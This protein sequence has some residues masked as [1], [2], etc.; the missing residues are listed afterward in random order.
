M[1][2]ISDWALYCVNTKTCRIPELTQLESGKSMIRNLP[3]KGVA[4][5]ARTSVSSSNLEPLPPAMIIAI[6]LLVRR[7]TKRPDFLGF[8]LFS[9]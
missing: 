9:S 3:A 8:I 7:L 5:L 2:W 6:V 4:G 1:C